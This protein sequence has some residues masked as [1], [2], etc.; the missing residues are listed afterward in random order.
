MVGAA[1]VA[2]AAGAAD[3]AE[4]AG[5]AAKI[6]ESALG[7][8]QVAETGEVAADEDVDEMVAKGLKDGIA[9]WLADARTRVPG[10]RGGTWASPTGPV[11]AEGSMRARKRETKQL[12][13]KSWPVPVQAIDQCDLHTSKGRKKVYFKTRRRAFF[14]RE[15]REA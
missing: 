10:E 7:G 1:S 2:D 3:A 4:M 14:L 5:A 11:G 8:K 13:G 15:S 12:A 9:G 6:M